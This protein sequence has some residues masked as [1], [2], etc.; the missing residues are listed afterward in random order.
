MSLAGIETAAGA[1]ALHI[2]GGL[3]PEPCDV[4]EGIRT[5]L[6]LGPS[7]PGFWTHFTAT[8][9]Y[10]DGQPDPLDRW[11][12]RVIGAIA[13]QFGLSA[14]FPFGGP[15]YQPFTRWA[16]QSR[17]T[18]ASP[19][20]FLVH[21]MA[22]LMVSYRGA[23]GLREHIALPAAPPNPCDSCTERPCLSACPVDALKPHAY[24]VDACKADLDREGNDCMARGCATRRA[25]PVSQRY[26][27]AEV[28]SAFHMEAFK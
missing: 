25:C 1:Q 11:S 16:R 21:D 7:E 6:L 3:H 12:A 19:V 22:G 14:F 9:E 27:R 2:L 4:P 28:Q 15:P 20:G 26:G 5:L 23:L 18:H 8:P 10:Q 24:D 17:R 13:D